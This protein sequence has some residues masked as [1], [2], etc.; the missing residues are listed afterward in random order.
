MKIVIPV[1]EKKPESSVCVS[2]GRAPYFMLHDTEGKTTEYIANTAAEAQ[3]GAGLKAA[4]LIVDC[5]AN[6]LLALRCGQNAADVLNAAQIKIH[7]AEGLRTAE[8][9][10]A[11]QEGKLTLMTQFQAGFHGRQ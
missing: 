4:Q 2:F 3:G 9:L 11:F 7:K 1:D 6:V 5:G 8:N 10:A